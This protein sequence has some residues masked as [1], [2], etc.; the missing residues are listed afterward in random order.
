MAQDRRAYFREYQRERR[1]RLRALWLA[2]DRRTCE[3]ADCGRSLRGK[4]R[5][6][7]FCSNP[8]WQRARHARRRAAG[9][10]GR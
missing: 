8:C 5:G 6:T 2:Q 3:A 7:R 9:A 1:E 4:R 10:S